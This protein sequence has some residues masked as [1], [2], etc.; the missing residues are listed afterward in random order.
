MVGEPS[1]HPRMPLLLAA[2]RAQGL[3]LAARLADG[4]VTTAG[5]RR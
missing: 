4:W 2:E 5:A 1:Q 3:A